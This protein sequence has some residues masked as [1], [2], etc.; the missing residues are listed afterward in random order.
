[1]PV[2]QYRAIDTTGKKVTGALDAADRRS[3]VRKL[4]AQ[5]LRPV[6]IEQNDNAE[7]DGELDEQLE[8]YGKPSHPI[9]LPFV[10][11]GQMPWRLNLLSDYWFC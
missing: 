2:F 7:N 5:G 9:K 8:L 10:K 6:Q 1:M 11:R 4:S 3:L